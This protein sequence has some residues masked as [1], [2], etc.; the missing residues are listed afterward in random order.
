MK[1][2]W[3]VGDFEPTLYRTKDVEAAVKTYKAG[4]NETGHYHK[5]ATE[6]TVVIDGE[7]LFNGQKFVKGDIVVLAPFEKTR[8]EALTDAVTAVVKIPGAPN[9]KYEEEDLPC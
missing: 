2:G 9:D 7:V 1:K 3:F 5:I 6:I 8:F 4:D